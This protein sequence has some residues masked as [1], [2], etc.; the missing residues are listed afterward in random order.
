MNNRNSRHFYS[1]SAAVSKG[2]PLCANILRCA[3]FLSL[4][5]LP[6]WANDTALDANKAAIDSYVLESLFENFPDTDHSDRQYTINYPPDSVLNNGC[7]AKVYFE[8]RDKPSA[9]NNTLSMTCN[10]PLWKVYIPVSIEIFKD[11]VVTAK[12]LSRGQPMLPS[13]LTLQRMPTSKLRSGYFTDPKALTDYE[14]QRTVKIG[15]IITPYMAK[16][17]FLVNRGDWVT[18]IS[19]SGGLRVTSTGEALRD[20][21]YGDQILVKN[22]KSNTRLKAWVVKKGVVSTQKDFN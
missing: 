6:S 2:L 11:V 3:A 17:P 9:G 19:G 10:E 18:I 4:L 5:S 8:W 7:P 15:Q 21:S 14:V 13:D 16:P 20:G 22:V 1:L 12:P